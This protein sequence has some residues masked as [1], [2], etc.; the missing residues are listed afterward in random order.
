M[1]PMLKASRS[2]F[3]GAILSV[4]AAL[5]LTDNTPPGIAIEVDKAWAAPVA[6]QAASNMPICTGSLDDAPPELREVYQSFADGVI[7]GPFFLAIAKQLGAPQNCTRTADGD[8]G[9]SLAYVFASGALT[10]RLQPDIEFY[11]QRLDLR[12]LSEDDAAR[13][14][15]AEEKAAFSDGCEISW[16][17]PTTENSSIDSS[18]TVTYRGDTCNCQAGKLYDGNTLIGLFFRSAC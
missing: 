16:A 18:R 2:V 17:S 3:V 15:R 10:A 6:A 12:G 5:S 13:L 14:L 4:V 7:S 9:L 11:E 8:S 1:I